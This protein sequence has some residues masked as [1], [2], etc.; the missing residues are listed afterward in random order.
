MNTEPTVGQSLAD[1]GAPLVTRRQFFAKLSYA[2]GGV[3]AALVGVPIIG[4]LF[5]PLFGRAPQEWQAIGTTSDFPVGETRLV[6]FRDPSPLPWAGVTSRTSAWVRR[7]SEGQF[8]AFAVNC[9][10]LGCPIRWLAEAKLFMCPCH[11]GVF[12][13]DGRVAAGPPPRPLFRYETRVRGD[14]IELLAGELP[15]TG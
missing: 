2:L 5:A 11:G 15:I 10:H 13:G 7:E 8:V 4:F 12:Y 14:Q 6:T 1:A 3:G 9:T